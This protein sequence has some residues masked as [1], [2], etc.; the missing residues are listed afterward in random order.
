MMWIARLVIM[1][2]G[3]G[4]VWAFNRLLWLSMG[5]G[6]LALSIYL[7]RREEALLHA[8]GGVE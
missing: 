3:L 7:A 4:L 6:F 1:T 5:A 2:A 8:A